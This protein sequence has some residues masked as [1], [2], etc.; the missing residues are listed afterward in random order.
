VYYRDVDGSLS[1]Q[2]ERPV[3]ESA[4]RVCQ[5]RDRHLLAAVDTREARRAIAT[6]YAQFA[7]EFSSV[8]P[9]LTGQ[10]LAHMAILGERSVSSIG[11]PGFRR[12]TRMFGF[13][14]ALG[15]RKSIG[16]LL[17]AWD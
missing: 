17:Q 11:G 1:R 6:Q 7:Y 5:L 3:I 9:D 4:F 13:P 16:A 8:A 10:A 12:L 15:L 2:R 14:P